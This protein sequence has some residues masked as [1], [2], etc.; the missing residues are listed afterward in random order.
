[1]SEYREPNG[2][3]NNSENPEMGQTHTQLLRVSQSD[4]G[5]GIS[6]LAGADRPLAREVSNAVFDQDEP[7]GNE[8][9][10]S[11]FMWMWGQFIDHDLSLT[12]SGLTQ[13]PANMRVPT[14]DLMFDPL[15]TGESEIQ[16]M[17]SAFDEETGT[18]TPREQINEIT[19]F[20]DAGSVY[21]SSQERMDALRSDDGKLIMSDG[22]L[23]GFNTAGLANAPSTAPNLFLA[24]DVRANEN[25]GLASLHTL[26]AREHN[27]LVEE[28]AEENPTLDG[29]T[30]F[31]E[32]RKTVEAQ[33][34]II[35]FN[36]FL[37]KLVGEDAI[38]AWDGY[39][40][41]VDP[42]IA[43]EFSTAAFRLGHTMLSSDILRFKEDGSESEFG[44]LQLRDA[45]FR[46]DRLSNEGGIE[47]TLR[48]AGIQEAE[49][50]DSQI[51]D[52]VRNFLF[53]PPG[54]GGFDLASLNIQRGRDHGLDD[55]NG[56][57][58]AYG[59][60]RAESFADITSDEVLQ[61]RL[62]ELYGTVDNIDLYV[63]GLAEDPVDGSLLGELFQ[64][65]VVDQFMRV[66]D[67]DSYWHE[68]RMSEAELEAVRGVTLAD[69]IERNS[70]VEVMQ[71][72]VFTAFDRVGGGDADD[73]LRATEDATLMLG[74]AGDDRMFG[75]DGQLEMHG[76][77]GEDRLFGRDGDDKM[78]GGADD[79]TLYGQNGADMLDGGDGADRV[80]GGNGDDA[81]FGMG[82]DDTIF[83]GRGEDMLVG[84]DGNDGLYGGSGSDI[85][86]GGAGD[87]FLHAGRGA[88]TIIFSQ[89]NDTALAFST[90]EDT[91]DFLQSDS[92]SSIDDLVITDQGRD[93]LVADAEGNSILL[94]G[95]QNFSDVN[96]LFREESSQPDV[97]RGGP[98]E[99]LNGTSG[100]D[101]FLDTEGNQVMMGK[102]GTDTIILAGSRD[103]YDISSVAGGNGYLIWNDVGYDFLWKIEQAQFD[104]ETVDLDELA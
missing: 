19:P 67:G 26:F 40:A 49:E 83:G 45:F 91:L 7:I 77:D 50:L 99:L 34:Q 74:G 16:F 98:N 102:G 58:E 36:E 12:E 41:D 25:I 101:F 31:Q 51:I 97:I 95:V 60:D 66:R 100:D 47:E 86:D 70:D 84:G 76:Q 21:G 81:L 82:D 6:T 73:V 78:W 79:D 85:L 5:D 11:N 29:E 63:G 23:M 62:E 17:R 32:A 89:G 56:A 52:D 53:G 33:L 27:R 104:D 75:N 1:M 42:Q 72:D 88:D 38:A 44:H 96:A 54:A 48:G 64:T 59:L 14:G 24:G 13:E 10:L 20:I 69:I 92:V 43:N 28:L 55:Y 39:K 30:L 37:P 35:T 80:I 3:N 87:D 68:N 2:A 90:I 61:E 71:E 22:D 103:D 8:L 9:G 65:I 4:Y 94:K 18:E 93:L 46:P 57:R 15:G